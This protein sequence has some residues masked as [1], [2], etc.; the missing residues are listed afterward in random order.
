MEQPSLL[1]GIL[2]PLPSAPPLG[3]SPQKP[4]AGRESQTTSALGPVAQTP[5]G[6]EN[7]SDGLLLGVEEGKTREE[8]NTNQY[9]SELSCH[10][11]E[12]TVAAERG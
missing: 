7:R 3:E 11:S 4:K 8:Q 10:S 12:I 9:F 1:L 2:G 6:L 5:V